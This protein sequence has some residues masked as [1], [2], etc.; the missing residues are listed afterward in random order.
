MTNFEIVVLTIFGI[1]MGL[2]VIAM[3]QDTRDRKR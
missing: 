3:W 2:F 1:M